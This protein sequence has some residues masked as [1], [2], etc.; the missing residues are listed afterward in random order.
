MQ[1]RVPYLLN[2]PLH[3]GARVF[4]SSG[5]SALVCLLA[6]MGEHPSLLRDVLTGVA[7]A[8]AGA[9]LKKSLSYHA[10]R[11]A[12]G[13][14]VEPE[15]CRAQ[16]VNAEQATVGA[17]LLHT[18]CLGPRSLGRDHPHAVVGGRGHTRLA[19][20]LR[21]N[22]RSRGVF[23]HPEDSLAEELATALSVEPF[24]G[25]SINVARRHATATHRFWPRS[26]SALPQQLAI[27]SKVFA[28]IGNIVDG[29]LR[30]RQRHTMRDL[31]QA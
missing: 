9:A 7:A 30:S 24:R 29:H 18:C 11:R 28:S 26:T 31:R 13:A 15:L 8:Q 12:M 5:T 2:A 25:R 21:N 23:A 6:V 14:P 20:R 1:E 17:P 22:A 16:E 19:T 10:V 3:E 4:C 27:L